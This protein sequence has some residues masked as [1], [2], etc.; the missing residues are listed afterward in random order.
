MPA[1][2]LSVPAWVLS[3]K[4]TR[5]QLAAGAGAFNANGNPLAQAPKTTASFALKYSQ[6][7]ANGVAVVAYTDQNHLHPGT[8]LSS[9]VC[10]RPAS[11]IFDPL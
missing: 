4:C 1:W 2:V 6:P 10:Q 5:A 3:G 7:M 11:T 8:V 9:M